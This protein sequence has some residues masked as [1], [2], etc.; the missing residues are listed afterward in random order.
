MQSIFCELW[1]EAGLLLSHLDE[2]Q[3]DLVLGADFRKDIDILCRKSVFQIFFPQ[4]GKSEI[5]L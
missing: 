5:G 2:N 1:R 3:I 4:I